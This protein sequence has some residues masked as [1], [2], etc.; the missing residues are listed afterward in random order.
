MLAHKAE[1]EGILVRLLR[2]RMIVVTFYKIST[3][4]TRDTGFLSVN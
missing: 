1:D 4:C 2:L 3:V